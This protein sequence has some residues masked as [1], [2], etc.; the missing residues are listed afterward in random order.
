MHGRHLWQQSLDV[1]RVLTLADAQALD[2]LTTQRV[3]APDDWDFTHR[4]VAR[5]LVPLLE[6]AV[7][8][9]HRVDGT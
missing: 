2:A 9:G 7:S 4:Q 3:L 8:A 6:D 1:S 5:S